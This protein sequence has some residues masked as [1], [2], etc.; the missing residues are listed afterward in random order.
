M[1]HDT[2]EL[3]VRCSRSAYASTLSRSQN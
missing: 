2:V 3:T 1:K